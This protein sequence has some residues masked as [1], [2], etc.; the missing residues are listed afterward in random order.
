MNL[1]LCFI[2]MVCCA[3][4]YTIKRLSHTLRMNDVSRLL[5][6]TQ[7]QQT[8]QNGLGKPWSY[9]DLFELSSKNAVDALSITSDGKNAIAIDTNH[10][11]EV[12]ASNLHLIKLFPENVDS[13]LQ[14]LITNHVNVDIIDVPKNELFEFFGKIGDAFYNVAIYY[15]VITFAISIISR[16]SQNSGIGPGNLMSP[17]NNNNKNRI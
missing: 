15:F 13:L 12:T 10:V 3:N 14:S 1:L 4:G 6:S 16:F 11:K 5:P 8:W 7:I 2:L 17:L 9:G